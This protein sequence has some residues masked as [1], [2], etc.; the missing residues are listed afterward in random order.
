MAAHQIS[1]SLTVVRVFFALVGIGTLLAVYS[2]AS[3]LWNRTAGLCAALLVST[4]IIFVSLTIVPYSEVLFIGL[5]CLALRNLDARQNSL[6]YVFGCVCVV[7][8]SLTRYEGWLF[9]AVMAVDNAATNWS[10]LAWRGALRG[11]GRDVVVFAAPACLW[12]LVGTT[13]T[14]ASEFQ[15]SE[16]LNV[17]YWSSLTKDLSELLR[18]QAG[19]FVLTLAFIGALASLR[20]GS[21]FRTHRRFLLFVTAV[22]LV[23]SLLDPW[24]PGNL[25]RVFVVV[26]AANI[27]AAGAMVTLTTRLHQRLM[28]EVTS[29]TLPAIFPLVIATIV[30]VV[31]MS[32]IPEFVRNASRNPVFYHAEEAGSWVGRQ[33]LEGATILL[34]TDD[35]LQPYAFSAYSRLDIHS[36][37]SDDFYSESEIEGHLLMSSTIIVLAVNASDDQLSLKERQLLSDIEAG[38]FVAV[39][40]GSGNVR[41]WELKGASL[42]P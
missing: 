1:E 38:R 22:L 20:S 40:Q 30:A 18:W 28:K 26:L 25:R 39:P 34:L 33:R 12:L 6:R 5:I 8:A 13:D 11:L 41:A 10:A 36:F 2:L 24:S 21:H 15:F 4:N 23:V 19:V 9:I 31:A 17:A 29:T 42:Q 3:H 14:R 32:Q 27:Y 7:G 16:R 35:A 37:L